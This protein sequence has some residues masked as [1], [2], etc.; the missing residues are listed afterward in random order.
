LQR[1]YGQRRGR[2]ATPQA[3]RFET[4]RCSQILR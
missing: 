4:C 2:V 3:C 1:R